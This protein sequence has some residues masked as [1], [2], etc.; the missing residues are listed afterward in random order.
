[1][2]GF[3]AAPASS[4]K[5]W[6]SGGLA[7]ERA[8]M[9]TIA[10]FFTGRA[11][12]A[13]KNR[14]PIHAKQLARIAA[15]ALA[16]YSRLA[17]VANLSGDDY[18]AEK[19]K[20]PQLDHA[21]KYMLKL[22]KTAAARAAGHASRKNANY[23]KALSAIAKIAQAEYARLL[24][25]KDALNG[26]DLGDDFGDD[27]GDDLGDDYGAPR[28]RRSFMPQ[29][30]RLPRPT[31]MVIEAAQE[32]AQDEAG[33]DEGGGVGE[34]YGA[35]V[36]AMLPALPINPWLALA[37]GVGGGYAAYRYMGKKA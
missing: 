32:N 34:D 18:G 11:E 4:D 10:D 7:Y 12:R 30:Q 16:E 31:P 21:K 6:T 13:K 14:H 29:S 22:S 17:K 24:K 35:D 9:R 28:G 36:F 20:T 5:R 8:R 25:L 26:D 1:M 27:F 23:A 3:Y 2:Y 33:T 19:S 37:L 15:I